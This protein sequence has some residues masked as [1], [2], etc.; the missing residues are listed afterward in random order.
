MVFYDFVVFHSI[1]ISD[2]NPIIQLHTEVKLVPHFCISTLKEQVFRLIL[3]KGKFRIILI[4]GTW[5]IYSYIV[6]LVSQKNCLWNKLDL[7]KK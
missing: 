4:E 7:I 5:L 3:T 2:G 6:L 1:N